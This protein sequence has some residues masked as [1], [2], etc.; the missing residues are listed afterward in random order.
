MARFLIFWFNTYLVLDGWR[1]R[2]IL[3]K[4]SRP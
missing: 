4:P 1:P 2:L 3:P